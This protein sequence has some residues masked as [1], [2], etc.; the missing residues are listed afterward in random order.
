MML[1]AGL[2]VLSHGAGRP[3]IDAW[4]GRRWI[5]GARRVCR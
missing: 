1:A 5:G 4:R 2:F 3:S